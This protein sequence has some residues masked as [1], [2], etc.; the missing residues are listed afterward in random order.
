V[1]HR[2]FGDKKVLKGAVGWGSEGIVGH[3][4]VSWYLLVDAHEDKGPGRAAFF[5]HGF[6]QYMCSGDL[7]CNNRLE[8]EKTLRRM[9]GLPSGGRYG[10]MFTCLFG[11]PMFLYYVSLLIWFF[12]VSFWCF[13]LFALVFSIHSVEGAI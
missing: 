8:E 9:G 6:I 3:V 11:K 7:N 1:G 2:I 12:K 10:T 5:H 13:F 4:F